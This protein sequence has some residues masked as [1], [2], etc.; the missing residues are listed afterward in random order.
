MRTIRSNLRRFLLCL[1]L[2]HWTNKVS[3]QR[4]KFKDLTLLLFISECPRA[5]TQHDKRRERGCIFSKN[6]ATTWLRYLFVC[7]LYGDDWQAYWYENWSLQLLHSLSLRAIHLELWNRYPK[8][9]TQIYSRRSNAHT[10]ESRESGQQDYL[11]QEGKRS[12]KK[13]SLSSSYHSTATWMLLNQL[14]RLHSHWLRTKILW[15]G[16]M[17]KIKGKSKIT[18]V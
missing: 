10:R 12:R 17:M 15:V 1:P 5:E 8:F 3:T 16:D 2:T 6:H 14:E 4:W 11:K 9:I 7:Q 18:L 13:C